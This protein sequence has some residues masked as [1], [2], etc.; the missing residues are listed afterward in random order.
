MDR[1]KMITALALIALS[2]GL[3]VWNFEDKPQQRFFRNEG[4]VFGTVYHIQ[5][6]Y[7]RDL[8]D[9][10]L[11]CLNQ[12]DSALSMFNP[13]S[14]ITRINRN[15]NVRTNSDFETVF[16]Q[17][18]KVSQLSGG[19]FDLTVAPLVN[20]WGFGFEKRPDTQGQVDSLRLLVGYSH[21]RLIE[22]HRIEKDNPE[23]QLDASAIAKG[24]ACDKVADK[25]QQLGVHNLLVEIGGE[26]VAIGHNSNGQPWNIGITKPIDDNTGVQQELQDRIQ[27]DNLRLA[28]SGNYRNF[29]YDGT[30]KRSH[31]IDPRT[32]YPV[33]HSLLS[34]TITANSC[35]EADALA[36]ACMVLGDTAA[37]QL[38]NA[39]PDAECYLIVASQDTFLVR[40]SNHWTLTR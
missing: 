2:I 6:E 12:V 26:V 8:L 11:V 9:T 32:G 33:R 17:A 5:Y 16:L 1:R 15:E 13:S 23:I 34:A 19:A 37:L 38:I 36:T 22:G 31:T 28:T 21:V 25:L 20:A 7:D 10:V 18:Q 39:I 27:T 30:Q 14:I 3:L 4:N 29:Y 35:M 24:F 40:T